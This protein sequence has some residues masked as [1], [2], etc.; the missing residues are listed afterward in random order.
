MSDTNGRLIT[1]ENQ[2]GKFVRVPTRI[3]AADPVIASSGSGSTGS[4]AGGFIADIA[5]L[6][7]TL[8]SG[9]GSFGDLP[10][11]GSI[12]QMESFDMDKDGKLDLVI[13]D[14]SGE[15]SILYGEKD[16][17]GLYFKRKI[18]DSGV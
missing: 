9:S 3:Q 1:L 5:S 18:L 11:R 6:Q 10:L 12:M 14:D 4:G 17:T 8:L 15:L 2:N 13:L 16:T 7:A